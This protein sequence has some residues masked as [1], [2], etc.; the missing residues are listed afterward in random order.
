M[1]V[2]LGRGFGVIMCPL[3]YHFFLSL[4]FFILFFFFFF[5]FFSFFSFFLFFLFFLFFSFFISVIF[6]DFIFIFTLLKRILTTSGK[7][8]RKV[9]WWNVIE[10][11]S[12]SDQEYYRMN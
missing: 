6:S 12:P 1:C 10:I 7:F 8:S 4:L 3:L 11:E 2:G 5:S 9:L